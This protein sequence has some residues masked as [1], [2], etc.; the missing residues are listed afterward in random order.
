MTF[1]DLSDPAFDV[2]SPEVPAAPG[3]RLSRHELGAALVFL[4]VAGM[5]TGARR[6]PIR[7]SGGSSA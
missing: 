2:S 6:C 7:F 3:D 4:A 5:E 1:F